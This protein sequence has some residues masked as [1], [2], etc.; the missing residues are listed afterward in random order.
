MAIPILNSIETLESFEQKL[1]EETIVDT[2]NFD[3]ED[4]ILE[5]NDFDNELSDSL[6][7]P[8]F[9]SQTQMPNSCFT[10]QK[11]D[12]NVPIAIHKANKTIK[13]LERYPLAKYVPF[14][15]LSNSF[16]SFF[17]VLYVI[18]IFKTLKEAMAHPG[19]R[20]TIEDEMNALLGGEN[21][22]LESLHSNKEVIGCK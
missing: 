11:T 2:G 20:A 13:S 18:T 12:L 17:T 21:W 19:Q 1:V 9:P 14:K 15:H 3:P 8:T 22:Q 10:S 16:A 7:H 5:T 4:I 6:P